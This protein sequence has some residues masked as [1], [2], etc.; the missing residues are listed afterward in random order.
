[1]PTKS[2]GKFRK[3]VPYAS[4][5]QVLIKDTELSLKAKGLYSIIECYIRIP[6]FTL[7]KSHLINQSTDGLR[8]F[9]SAWYELKEHGYLKQYRIREAKGWRYEYDLLDVPDLETSATIDI[10]LNGEIVEKNSPQNNTYE[11]NSIDDNNEATVTD[12]KS[13][14]PLS[15]PKNTEEETYEQVLE[16]VNKNIEYN[17]LILNFQ[18]HTDINFITNIRDI[19]VETIISK[20]KQFVINKEIKDGNEV[21]TTLKRFNSTHLMYLKRSFEEFS[22]NISNPKAYM[23]TAIY[24]AVKTIGISEKLYGIYGTY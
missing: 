17:D 12:N 18:N 8:A 21:R 6:D 24:N 22:D 1:M 15:S 13:V 23:L 10:D 16:K 20:T 3:K 5:S 19:I 7:Y 14:V 4:V 9:N 11:Q 2:D